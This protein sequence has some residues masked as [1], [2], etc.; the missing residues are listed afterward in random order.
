M[1]RFIKAFLFG[2]TG[3]F[4]IITLLSLLITPNVKVSRATVINHVPAERLY[5]QISNLKNWQNWHPMFKAGVATLHLGNITTGKNASCDIVYNGRTTHLIITGADSASITFVVQSA[6]ENNIYNTI[7]LTPVVAASD[8]RVEW[9]ALTK[10]HWY[11]WEKF[12]AIFIDKLTGPG[13][14]AAL[15]GLKDFVEM[16]PSK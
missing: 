16:N 14:D 7:S 5:S 13:Y 8:T 12:Y 15:T 4:I 9:Q 3:L 10:L 1:L 2:I 11:P 6:G